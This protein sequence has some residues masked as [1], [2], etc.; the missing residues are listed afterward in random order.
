MTE[1]TTYRTFNR[2]NYNNGRI[3]LRD[4]L[5]ISL[6]KRFGFK[7]HNCGLSE[8]EIYDKGQALEKHRK[9]PGVE[10]GK[11][12]KWNVKLVCSECHYHLHPDEYKNRN[13]GKSN[14]ESS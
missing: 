5:F 14:T 12:Q 4:K 3:I 9:I 6:A 10:G 2:Y 7:Y 1:T 8:E 13:G 11:Y